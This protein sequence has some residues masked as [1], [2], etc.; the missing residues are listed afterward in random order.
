MRIAIVGTG[1][2]GL[3]T[4]TCLA[5]TGNEVTCLDVDPR[6]IE[7]LLR[8]ECPIYEPGLEELIRRNRKAHRLMFTSE[9]EAA[10]DNAE[11]IFICVGTPTD[12][13]GT[14]DLSAV[15]VAAGQVGRAIEAAPSAGPGREPIVVVKS[16]VP[17]GTCA[18]VKEVVA[19]QT[20]GAASALRLIPSS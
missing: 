2:V 16:T 20:R 6:K 17:V 11:A 9:A 7:T 14:P 4:G 10:Y 13:Q 12:A 15:L 8:G 1:Y 18:K 19:G 3:V 5:N